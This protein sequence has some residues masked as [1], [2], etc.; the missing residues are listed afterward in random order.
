MAILLTGGTGKTSIGIAKLLQNAK[1][2]FL[3]ASRRGQAAAPFEMPAVS[4]NWLDSSTFPK[5]FE[6]EFF[7][8]ESISTVYLVAPETIDPPTC[9]NPFIDYAI[10]QHDVKRF[11]LLADSYAEVGGQHVGKVWQHL[12]NRHVDYCVL[13]PTWFMGPFLPQFAMLVV[14]NW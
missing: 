11:V 10:K 7:G 14:N 3:L 12:L 9:L 8:G 13:L 5:P 6:H 2:P 1:I 4:F